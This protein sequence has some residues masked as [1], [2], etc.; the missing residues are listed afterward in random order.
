MS[1][2]SE[3]SAIRCA[4][5]GML[6]PGGDGV[7]RVE[8][9]ENVPHVGV[10]RQHVKVSL[11]VPGK[12]QGTDVP[13]SILLDSGG[14]GDSVDVSQEASYAVA[15]SSVDLSIPGTCS[16]CV[17]AFGTKRCITTHTCHLRLVIQSRWGEVWIKVAFVVLPG[18]ADMSYLGQLPLRDVL[19]IDVMH[20]SK[21]RLKGTSQQECSPAFWLN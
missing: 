7:A 8:R 12:K 14:N 19:G 15:R 3:P 9:L 20:Q 13:L 4:S 17:T 6:R 21:V 11:T 10:L 16:S 18:T 1:Q 5:V 2:P